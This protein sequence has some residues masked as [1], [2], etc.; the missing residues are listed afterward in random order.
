MP[1]FH[2]HGLLL[3]HGKK[4]RMFPEVSSCELYQGVVVNL[5]PVKLFVLNQYVLE[6]AMNYLFIILR[7]SRLQIE[8]GRVFFAKAIA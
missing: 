6:A 7:L 3:F 5:F 2:Q 8:Q 4:A 1:I